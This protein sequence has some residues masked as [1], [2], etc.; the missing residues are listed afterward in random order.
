[1]VQSHPAYKPCGRRSAGPLPQGSRS[2]R[3][4]PPPGDGSIYVGTGRLLPDPREHGKDIR[5]LLSLLPHTHVFTK[6]LLVW[7][8]S[9]S[10]EST[11]TAWVEDIYGSPFLNTM[12]ATSVSEG[13]WYPSSRCWRVILGLRLSPQQRR[14]KLESSRAGRGILGKVTK[15]FP[16]KF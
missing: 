2:R 14:P 12:N 8:E 1:V 16:I 13:Q 6:E 15:P 5:P 3:R 11:Y 7:V 10:L 4:S 9:G